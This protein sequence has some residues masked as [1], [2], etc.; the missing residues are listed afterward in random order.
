VFSEADDEQ[1]CES[2]ELCDGGADR[3]PHTTMPKSTLKEKRDGEEESE[4]SE[5]KGQEEIV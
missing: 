2:F 5:E 3:K 4:S 1:R